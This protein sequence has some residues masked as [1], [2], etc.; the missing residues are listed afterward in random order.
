MKMTPIQLANEAKNYL[1]LLQDRAKKMKN[2]Y[3]IEELEVALTSSART[4]REIL[5]QLRS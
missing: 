3:L 2:K 4:V 5:E 1:W